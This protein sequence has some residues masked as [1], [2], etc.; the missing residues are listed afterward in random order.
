MLQWYKRGAAYARSALSR[1][2]RHVAKGWMIGYT[3][4][5]TTV[6]SC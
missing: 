5:D 2:T 3:L 4:G 6:Q 1:I